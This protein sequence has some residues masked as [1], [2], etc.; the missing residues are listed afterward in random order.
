M[1]LEVGRGRV[2]EG[3]SL[4]RRLGPRRRAIVA[5]RN[6]KVLRVRPKERQQQNIEEE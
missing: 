6:G 4:S 3:E 2:V 5:V 1:R